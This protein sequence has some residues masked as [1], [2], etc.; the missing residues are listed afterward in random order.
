MNAEDVS[1]LEFMANQVS[2]S[3]LQVNETD[4]VSRNLAML[5]C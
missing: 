2:S 5:R 3:V 4:L 1:L